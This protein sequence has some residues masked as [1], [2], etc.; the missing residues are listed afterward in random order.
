VLKK[1]KK[2][3]QKSAGAAY[4]PNGAKKKQKEKKNKGLVHI[5]NVHRP[6][7]RQRPDP[8]RRGV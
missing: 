6:G 5:E 3:A 1:I 7:F 2:V 4:H 8:K